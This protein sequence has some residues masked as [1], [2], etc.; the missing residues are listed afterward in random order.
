MCLAM[1]LYSY[2]IHEKLEISFPNNF[3][4]HGMTRKFGEKKNYPNTTPYSTEWF[5]FRVDG[6]CA[7]SFVVILIFGSTSCFFV[8]VPIVCLPFASSYYLLHG[9]FSCY[10]LVA[11]FHFI[12]DENN[13]LGIVVFTAIAGPTIPPP[14]ILVGS[15]YFPQSNH[16]PCILPVSGNIL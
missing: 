8:V 3:K 14:Q 7:P 13:F 15:L 11:F 16:L 12:I 4:R 5:H 10:S 6:I 2:I 9:L 1:F